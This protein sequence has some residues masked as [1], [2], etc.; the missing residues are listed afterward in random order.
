MRN[1]H[2]PFWRRAVMIAVHAMRIGQQASGRSEAVNV[3][4][5]DGTPIAVDS[6]G[7]G[8][9]LVLVDGAFGHRGFG[10]NV[11]LAPLL[12]ERFTVIRYDRRGRGDSGDTPPYAVER[13]LEDLEAVIAQAGG[14]A[15]VYG[16]SSGGVLGLEAAHRI[17]GIDKL[18]L[19]ELPFVVDDSRAPVPDD[20]ASHLEDLVR[21]GRRGKAVDYF[22]ASG[23]GVPGV[24]VSLMRFMPGRS[25]LKSVA[26]TAPYDA[27]LLGDSGSGAPLPPGRWPRAT[28]TLVA[29]GEKSPAWMRNGMRALS[30][31]L[32]NAELRV[33]EGQ[34][35]LVKPKVLAP[36]LEEF[37]TV[38]AEAE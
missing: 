33:L 8:P 18:A 24:F 17:A 27:A 28:P 7:Q 37:F 29:V 2:F 19:Y 14:K 4:S 30:D 22:M 5:A 13:E 21:A 16:I 3:E 12:A 36:V 25:K 10:P 32:P 26:H 15:H 9:A 31:V 6:E 34:T 11:K 20:F 38:R 35:H 23:V 1:R